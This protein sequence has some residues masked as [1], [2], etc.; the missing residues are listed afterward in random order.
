MVGLTVSGRAGLDGIATGGRLLCTSLLLVALLAA[1]TDAQ[2]TTNLM[3]SLRGAPPHEAPRVA[4]TRSGHLRFLAAPPSAYFSTPSAPAAGPAQRARIFLEQWRDLL[5]AASPAVGFEAVRVRS[6]A[7]RSNVH[8]EQTYDGI[9]V[10]GARVMVQVDNSGG[11]ECVLSDI[12]RNVERLDS[13]S[14]STRPAIKAGRAQDAAIALL[15]AENAELELRASPAVLMVYAPSV[16]GRGGDPQL[17]WQTEVSNVGPPAVKE[18]VLVD[19]H[20][21][22]LAFRYPLI[23]DAIN[24]S[25]YD[26]DNKFFADPGTLV[27]SEGQPASGIADADLAYDYFGDT[28][29]FYFNVHGRDS[30]DDAGS[31]LSATVRYCLLFYPCPFPNAFW[32]GSRMYFGQGYTVDDV[33]GHELTHG[34]TENESNLIYSDQSGAINESLSDMWGEWIDQSNAAGNDA[35]EVRWLMGEDL[36]IDAIRDMAD[37]PAF[38]DPDRMGSPNFYTGPDDNG[39]VHINS[40]VGNKLC[41]LLTDG[42]TFNGYNIAGMGVAMTA[43]LF[44]ECQISLLTPASDYADLYFAV[45]QA[46]V[47]LGWTQAQRDNLEQACLAVEIKPPP[48]GVSD[49]LAVASD[50]DP[51]ISLSWTNPADPGLTSIVIRRSTA[52]F[53]AD[54]NDGNLVYDALGS[55]KV[56]GP[57][58]IGTRYY[59]S[60]WAFYG[61]DGYSAPAHAQAVAGQVAIDAFTEQFTANDNDLDNLMITFTPDG[62]PAFYRACVEPATDFPTDPTGGTVITLMTD[63]SVRVILTGGVNVHLYGQNYSSFYVATNGYVTF[64]SGDSEY[65][66]SFAAH[67]SLPRISGLFD[68]L[69]PSL[70]GTVSVKQLS[71]R[72]AVTYDG[73]PEFLALQ[74]NSFQIEMFY[75]GRIR[76]TWLTIGALD[77][78]AGLSDGN[79]VPSDLLESDLSAYGSC[80]PLG[81]LDRDGDVDRDD[82]AMLEA[83]LNGPGQLSP[84]PDAD[85]DGDNDC[86]LADFAVFM[87]SFIGP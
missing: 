65:D 43:E 6:G 83:S 18:V 12:L 50:G 7:H 85:L 38:G 51:D 4:R 25:I 2:D 59:Y 30:L 82:Y 21:G 66:E 31:E 3:R 46:A 35:P 79:G 77:G 49:F 72:A 36:P 56:D 10:F 61:L 45:A 33:V 76:I 14:P 40:G 54:P 71:D 11:V 15:A 19:A 48:Q 29:D 58:T 5:V 60:A 37:P 70:F 1:A 44:Y 73:V 67:F 52:G 17:V 34:V 20:T 26:A 28:Y 32:D 23:H 22:R 57:L 75:D 24:R 78:L 9:A 68:D 8:F 86:D 53:P 74:T 16:L 80:Y 13:G 81:D 41:Y 84:N 69:D 39:G 27:R 87:G 55:S 47:N 42:D 62:S 63:T 64:G